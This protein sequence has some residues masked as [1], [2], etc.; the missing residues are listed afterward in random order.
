MYL[1]YHLKSAEAVLKLKLM[2]VSPLAWL[3]SGLLAHS[4]SS[5]TEYQAGIDLV[6]LPAGI[7]LGIV[8]VFGLW[9]AVGIV[10]ANPILFY[11]EF[12][13][14]DFF[15]LG[16]NSL[17]CGLVPYGAVHAVKRMLSIDE[18]LDAL[19]PPHLPVLALAV[20]VTT[21]L[22]LNINFTAF[23]NKPGSGIW[24]NT[25]AMMLRDFRGCLAVLILMSVGIAVYRRLRPT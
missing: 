8:L 22:A 14:R 18:R 10:I 19:L 7:R 12:G 9:G 21:P 25:S 6:Y 5:V 24:G 15:E 1:R 4:I 23:H 2:F 11:L 17:I 3:V 16:T 20:S 13:Q